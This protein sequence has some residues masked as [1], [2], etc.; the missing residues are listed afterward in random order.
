LGVGA[1]VSTLLYALICYG[2]HSNMVRTFDVTV[3]KLAG[4]G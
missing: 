3:R 2:L 4:T 1:L